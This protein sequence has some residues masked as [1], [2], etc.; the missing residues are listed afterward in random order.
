MKKRSLFI[1]LA[2]VIV[3]ATVAFVSCKKETENALNQRRN[4]T[5]RTVDISQIDDM[6]AYFKDFRQKMTENKSDEAMSIEDA[7][8]HLACLAN[9]DYC[10]INVEYN[11]FQFDTI[12]MTFNVTD[13]TIL[14]SDLNAAYEQI[15]N[16]IQQFKKE[17]YHSDQNLYF[18]NVFIQGNGFA[19]L[20]LMTSF[21]T[22]SKELDDHYWYFPDTFNFSIDSV[23]SYYF[24]GSP[25]YSWNYTAILE[26]TR[27]LNSFEHHTNTPDVIN[28]LPTRN[29][30]FEYPNWPDPYESPFNKDSRMYAGIYANHKLSKDELCYCL[31]SYLGLGY[32]YII[33]NYY[34]DN[35]HPVCW[36][37]TAHDSVLPVDHLR[38]YYHNMQ[39]QYGQLY[40]NNSQPNP[41]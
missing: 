26:L 40:S 39:V 16:K 6:T 29:Y 23:C 31:D 2:V 22:A 36:T 5:Q 25:L 34:V 3:A 13:G 10:R 4:N 30:T 14:M 17:L 11:D 28:Y 12:D 33:D 9:I 1:T 24:P 19:K 20:A 8:W 7:A 27:I 32:D 37:I 35:E 18:I 21:I 15:R 38:S 41:D